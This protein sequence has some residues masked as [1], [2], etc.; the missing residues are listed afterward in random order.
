MEKAGRP[1]DPSDE[2]CGSLLKIFSSERLILFAGAGVGVRAGLVDWRGFV[3]HLIT[4]AE[5]YEKETAAIMAARTQAGLLA[6]AISY[7]KL[8]R[9]IPKGVKF[10]ELAAPFDDRKANPASLYQLVKLPFD[11]IVT[12]NYDRNLDHALAAVYHESPRTF[13]LDDGSLRQAAF[14][15]ERYIARIHGRTQRPE[16][17]VTSTEDFSKLD[18]NSSYKDFLL[19]SILTRRS[20][21]FLGYSFLDPAI[22]KILDLLEKQFSPNYPRLHYAILPVSSDAEALAARL[23][24]FNIR[25]ITYPDHE[26]LWN[27]IESLPL[28]LVER[29]APT[30][31]PR[32]LPLPFEQMR[33]FLASCYVQSKMSRVAAPL[34]DLVVRGIILSL[35]EQEKRPA[36][37]SQLSRLLRQVIPLDKDDADLVTARAVDALVEKGLVSS[38][39][40][41]IRIE[42]LP[43]KVLEDNTDT[44]VRGTLNRLLVR[45]GVDENAP[46][47]GAV[48]TVLQEV[49]LTHGWD[50]GAEFA[51]AKT[52]AAVDL[53]DL[54]KA[55]LGRI[56]T[57]TSF[58]RV[59]QIANALYDLLRKPDQTEAQILADLARLSFGLNVILK[60]GNAALKLEALPEHIYFDASILLP[61]ITDG[62]PFRP[63]YE[64]AIDKLRK[65]VAETGKTCELLVISEFLNEIVS[66]RSRAIRMVK[67][68][69]L[70]DP[71][72]LEKH[73]LYYG[74]EN[75]N[76]FVGSYAS[77]VGRQKHVVPFSD[78]LADAA[79]YSSEQAVAT[80]IERF[81]IRTVHVPLGDPKYR[82]TYRRFLSQLG[83]AYREFDA[84]GWG[85]E[86]ADVLVE[87]EALQLAQIELELGVRRRTIFVTADKALRQIVNT[88]RLGT[89]WNVV[90]SHLGLVQLTDLLLGVEAEPQSLA[91]ILWGPMEVDAHAAL[92]DY[93]IDLALKKYDEA[94]VMTLPEIIGEFVSEAERAAKLEKVRFFTREVEDKAVAA[95]FLDRF[96]AQ[97]FEKMADVIRKRKAQQKN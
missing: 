5:K 52:S 61:A 95:R 18:E 1:T 36:A 62:H 16:C 73:I 23:A 59:S 63:V 67:E 53:Y 96:E 72:K 48:R 26:A 70:D 32:E 2:L 8:C 44:L 93:F 79:P 41:E 6:D 42:K 75:T 9:L 81:G 56:L 77:W 20:C 69:G 78:F 57:T 38:A 19:Q 33:I 17:M 55:S 97:F 39:N 13:E 84:V 46:Y 60:V 24:G 58:E 85:R 68:L 86:K 3:A 80:F 87:H 74:A 43:P 94:L 35:L 76:V 88:I 40:D 82:A 4:V 45:E 21:F 50:L 29:G 66:H 64:S 51:G 10:G 15:S 90:T 12:T 7:Y 14:S 92:R 89:A 71:G 31:R 91:R 34:R 27:C 83:A 47:A 11:A 25:V 37:I 54:I 28:K 49:F 65:A 22:S 30:P